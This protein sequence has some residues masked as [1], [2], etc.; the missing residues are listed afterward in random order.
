MFAPAARVSDM[1]TCPKL[2]PLQQGNGTVA[3]V[4]QRPNPFQIY[5]RVQSVG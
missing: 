4:P 3:M 5:L 2:E 1:H